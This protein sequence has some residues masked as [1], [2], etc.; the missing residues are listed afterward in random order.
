MFLDFAW[1]DLDFAYDT[2]S[3]FASRPDEQMT[4]SSTVD[5]SSTRP[6][7]KI[8]LL[9]RCEMMQVPLMIFKEVLVLLVVK[10]IELPVSEADRTTG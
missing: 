6:C 10:Q 2:I 9:L 1:R 7:K 5:S 3:A 8:S 4:A